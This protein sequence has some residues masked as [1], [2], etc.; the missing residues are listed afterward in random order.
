MYIYKSLIYLF[1]FLKI[2]NLGEYAKE[3]SLW[4]EYGLVGTTSILPFLPEL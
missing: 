2:D 3:R 4:E 1:E